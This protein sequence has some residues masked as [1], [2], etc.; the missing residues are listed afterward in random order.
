MRTISYRIGDLK[1]AVI[2]I[3][4]VAENEH[5]RVNIDASEVFSEYPQAVATLTVQPPKGSAYPA[6]VTRNGDTIVWDIKDSDLVNRGE[7]EIQLTFTEGTVV[8]KSCISRISISRSIVGNGEAPEP[9]QDWIN[10]AN[11]LLADLEEKKDTDYWKGEKGDPGTP[12][13]PGQP[14]QD[15]HTPVLT[16]NK[17]GKTTTIYADG[18]Q[19]AQIQDGQD[20]QGGD[21]IDDTAGEGDTDKTW[22]A[23]KLDTELSDVKNAIEGIEDELD[24]TQ[25]IDTKSVNPDSEWSQGG[26]VADVGNQI[27][28]SSSQWYR[29]GYYDID[30][31]D[32]SFTVT[33]HQSTSSGYPKYV[34]FVNSS[35]IV[36]SSVGNV[37][38]TEGDYTYSDIQIPNG[39]VKMYVTDFGT[40]PAEQVTVT[41]KYYSEKTDGVIE[42]VDK[43][44]PE[45]DGLKA[46]VGELKTEIKTVPNKNIATGGLTGEV[47]SALTTTSSEWY[48]NVTVAVDNSARKY[49]IRTKQ[50]TSNSYKHY[51]WFIDANGIILIAGGEVKSAEGFYTYTV[52]N[53]PSNAKNLAVLT[54]GT[55]N[56]IIIE[57]EAVISI[58]SEMDDIE[59]Y[60]AKKGLSTSPYADQLKDNGRVTVLGHNY[61]NKFMNFVFIT[62]THFGGNRYPEYDARNNMRAFVDTANERWVDFAAHGGDIITDYGL[63]RNDALTWMD[64]TLG[65]F[66]D[67]QVPLL[68]AKGNHEENNAYYQPVTDTSNLD[69]EHITYYVRSDISFA[70]VTESTWNGVD[71]LYIADPEPERIPDNQFT[72]LAQLGFAGDVVRNSNDYL[73]GYFYKDF[74]YNKI[75]VIVLDEYQVQGT[76]R[77]GISSEQVAW[78]GGTALVLGNDKSDYSVMII[79]HSPNVTTAVSGLINAFKN[80]TSYT[81]GGQTYDFTSQGAKD[82]IMYLHGHEHEDTYVSSGGF[83]NIGVICGYVPA[84]SVETEDEIRFSIFTIDTT[85]KKIYETRIGAGNSREFDY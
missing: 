71:D 17:T 3:G 40:R 53:I 46:N 52:E 78:L 57:K 28:F 58:R 45:V 12:G 70:T 11:E 36:L 35:G 22:S 10:D 25:T 43:M 23:D 31:N 33:T 42:K 30:E 74:D 68:I 81:T 6:T 18:Q 27:S 64:D 48:N 51:F 69:W 61:E 84:E 5:T 73:G 59:H 82:F 47:G 9:V 34:H 21:V 65:I 60:F 20:G 75:R 7:G 80:G 39:A 2:E 1:K 4:Y 24:G 63:T 79:S 26:V 19:L 54:S 49:I 14:G 50:S 38:S 32:I 29:Y 77:I 16:S 67:I 62:D 56:N 55:T 76:T 85:A 44:K 41:K 13:E 15:G 66:G 72:M 8:V 83:N 37:E